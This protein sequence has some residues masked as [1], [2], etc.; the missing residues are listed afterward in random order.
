MSGANSRTTD[1]A[2][3]ITTCCSAPKVLRVWMPWIASMMPMV[4]ESTVRMGS[5]RMPMS[6]I[7]AKMAGRRTGWLRRKPK[8]SQ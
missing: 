1:R 7:S 3:P 6:I 8:P 5:A 2:M 4:A